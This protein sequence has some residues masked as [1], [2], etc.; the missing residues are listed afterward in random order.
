MKVKKEKYPK[1]MMGNIC[2]Y[3]LLED[4]SILIASCY[5]DRLRA[6][7]D[8]KTA[9]ENLIKIVN[10][11]SQNLLIPVAKESREL[12]REISED[13]NLA[14]KEEYTITDHIQIKKVEK[15]KP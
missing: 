15:A 9:I 12:W 8:R 13:Y 3:D 4:G 2:G 14:K 1:R 11:T 7:A 5:Q 10:E 6:I